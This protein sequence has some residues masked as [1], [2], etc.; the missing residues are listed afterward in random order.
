MSPQDKLLFFLRHRPALDL[1][2]GETVLENH[3]V[4]PPSCACLPCCSSVPK[5][6]PM[7]SS[8][9]T[10][11]DCLFT[12]LRTDIEI[13]L[14][15][16]PK[17]GNNT[18]CHALQELILFVS[19][20]PANGST[21]DHQG[22]LH[23]VLIASHITDTELHS[24]GTAHQKSWKAL[25]AEVVKIL[26]R[27]LVASKTSAVDPLSY[28]QRIGG[29]EILHAKVTSIA[30]PHRLNDKAVFAFAAP[31]SASPPGA[32]AGAGAGPASPVVVTVTRA[33]S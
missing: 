13:D 24:G 2:L 14:H 9:L 31:P 8:P 5:I 4:T 33:K 25:R 22:Y 6:V 23:A 1:L 27:S 29:I 20:A 26:K 17:H 19:A 10:L 32:Q 7:E 28:A 18:Q 15:F 16:Y 3:S 30:R 11:R 21:A 12:A